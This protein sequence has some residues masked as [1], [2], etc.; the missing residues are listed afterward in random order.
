MEK[1]TF[2]CCICGK[3]ETT[4]TWNDKCGNEL[5]EHQMCFT[6]NHWR[7]H[8]EEDMKPENKY[9]WAIVD[10]YHYILCPP[11]TDYFKGFGGRM[12][13]FVFNDGHEE[14]CNN[15]WCQGKIDEEAHHGNPATHPHWREIM[16]DNA[17]IIW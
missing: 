15:T 17:K 6:C 11:T 9:K 16:P 4:E 3:E 2:K 8:H 7:K 10:G 5:L 14:F 1:K 12:F 13:H